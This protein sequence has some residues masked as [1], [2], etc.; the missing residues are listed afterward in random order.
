MLFLMSITIYISFKVTQNNLRISRNIIRIIL[1]YQDYADYQWK[2][3]DKLLTCKHEQGDFDQKDK[4]MNYGQNI[5]K[6]CQ[7]LF[8]TQDCADLRLRD[9]IV[10]KYNQWMNY[11]KLFRL[12]GLALLYP[13]PLALKIKFRP[14]MFLLF[15]SVS[16]LQRGH[17]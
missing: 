16:H 13:P 11:K 4:R 1:D 8:T 12:V 5:V 2:H 3:G 15:E 6:Y 10:N 17:N 14:S 7:E 9:N